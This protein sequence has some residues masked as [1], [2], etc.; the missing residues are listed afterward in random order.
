MSKKM[1]L[2]MVAGCFLLSVASP[3]FAITGKE[4]MEKQKEMH[5]VT[6]EYGEEKMLLIDTKSKGKEKRDLKRFSKDFG[7]DLNRYLVAFLSPADIKGTALLTWEQSDGKNDQWLYMPATKK[8]QRIAKGSKKTYFM[9]TDFTYEDME[10]EDIDNFNYKII[11]EEKF[12]HDKKDWDCYVIESTPQNK[13]KARESGYTLRTMW[14]SKDN[15]LT[16]KVEF[17]G[18]RNK[19]IKIQTSFS[20]ENVKGTVWRPKKTIMDN[21]SKKHKTLTLIKKRVI[22]EN[23]K[24]SVFTERFITTG[25]HVQ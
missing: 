21:K 20:F 7:N 19:L 2:V 4:V 1:L 8:M 6:T 3:V 9:G 11:R 18:R 12:N 14:I 16:L 23:I 22:D 10:P 15:L 25:K 17:Y 13:Q 5:K 24:D